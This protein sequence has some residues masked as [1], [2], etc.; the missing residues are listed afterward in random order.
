MIVYRIIYTVKQ[1]EDVHCAI[2]PATSRAEGPRGEW[3]ERLDLRRS[4]TSFS[5]AVC[6]GPWSCESKLVGT[7]RVIEFRRA[8]STQDERRGADEDPE[9]GPR[10]RILSHACFISSSDSSPSCL[11]SMQLVMPRS[12]LFFFVKR[13][14]RRQ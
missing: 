5:A 9:P 11:P 4:L 10:F 13:S 2:N 14:S 1:A 3:R 7:V 8:V 12:Q 6:T